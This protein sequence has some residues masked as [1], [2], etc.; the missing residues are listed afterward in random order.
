MLISEYFHVLAQN[1]KLTFSIHFVFQGGDHK[2]R[3]TNK[4]QLIIFD[5]NIW[6]VQTM[7]RLKIVPPG[8]FYHYPG[9]IHSTYMR[10]TFMLA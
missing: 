9:I 2:I 1:E 8:K 5:Q 7:H 6:N 4:R 3:T 10:H